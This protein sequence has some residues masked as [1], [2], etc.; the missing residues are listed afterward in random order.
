MGRLLP[1]VN[2]DSEQKLNEADKRIQIGPISLVVFYAPWCGHC[3]NLEPVLDKLE[4]SPDRSV[5]VV[6]VR[7][8]MVPKS[9]L[10]NVKFS[11][12]PHLM[13]VK[14]DKSIINFK[15]PDG[16]VSNSIPDYR[17]SLAS[18]VRN[19]GTPE[20]LALLNEDTVSEDSLKNVSTE[21]VVN[22]ANNI[23]TDRLSNTEV[24]SLNSQLINATSNKLK[25]AKQAGG[26]YGDLMGHLLAASKGLAP[27]AALFLAA[28]VLNKTR[29]SRT[30]KKKTRRYKR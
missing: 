19:A 14:K 29:R 18:I 9:T 23:V 11:G 27:A 7:D 22:E 13:L 6:R 30:S 21:T 1:P 25:V 16:S 5:Q 4:N 2:I 20:G 10:N 15:K 26:G 12:Y 28:T 8:D 3:R 17:N 24:R